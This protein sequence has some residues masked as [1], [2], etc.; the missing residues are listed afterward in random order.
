M[1]EWLKP[2]VLKADS[3]LFLKPNKINK[4]FCQPMA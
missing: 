1:G 4:S 2:A 3:A